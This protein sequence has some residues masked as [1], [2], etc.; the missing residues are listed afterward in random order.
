M[1]DFVSMKPVIVETLRSARNG[2]SVSSV[3]C[4]A[5]LRQITQP[6]FDLILAFVIDLVRLLSSFSLKLQCKLLYIHEYANLADMLKHLLKNIS[7]S[8]D[9]TNMAI[10]QQFVFTLFCNSVA[11]EPTQLSGPTYLLRS[12]NKQQQTN[13][14]AEM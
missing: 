10:D 3:K 2:D 1:E 4:T 13:C 12:A 6:S 5:Y 7:L 14:C 11:S 9:T 8:Y